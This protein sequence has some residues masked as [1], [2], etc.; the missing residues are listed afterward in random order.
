MLRSSAATTDTA[1]VAAAPSAAVPR[2]A[3]TQSI[4]AR[5]SPLRPPVATQPPSSPALP[6]SA[7][8]WQRYSAGAG[9]QH[10]VAPHLQAIPPLGNCRLDP[11]KLYAARFAWAH[12]SRR[13]V[14]IIP[15]ARAASTTALLALTLYRRN[16][17]HIRS[18]LCNE[19]RLSYLRRES[20][21]LRNLV[22]IAAFCPQV[23]R[24]PPTRVFCPLALPQW[25]HA[26]PLVPHQYRLHTESP[27]ATLSG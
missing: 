16:R 27:T 5:C 15:N 8:C 10:V 4:R 12:S 23:P 25:Q 21:A 1:I 14:C 20:R 7:A 3:T 6:A 26:R 17:W 13:A 18:T 11:L 24:S 9:Q 19:V 22:W 2:R